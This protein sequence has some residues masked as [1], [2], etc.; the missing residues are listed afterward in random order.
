[1]LLVEY[2]RK[3]IEAVELLKLSRVGLVLMAVFLV[4]GEDLRVVAL[5][6]GAG[7][8]IGFLVVGAWKYRIATRAIRELKQPARARLLKG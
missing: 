8:T 4:A 2:E 1:V 6:V 3:R 7:F 5:P